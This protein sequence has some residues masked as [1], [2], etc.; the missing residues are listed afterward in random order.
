MKIIYAWLQSS[1]TGAVL[2]AELGTGGRQAG[3]D[4]GGV[5][6]VGRGGGGGDEEVVGGGG[7]GG[8]KG[9][10]EGREMGGL[11]EGANVRKQFKWVL[12]ES[13][14]VQCPFEKLFING[15]PLP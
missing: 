12:P 11:W 15:L 10:W 6:Q 13:L 2:S 4:Q 5:G 8:G 9:L 3:A 14:S 7:G 1:E